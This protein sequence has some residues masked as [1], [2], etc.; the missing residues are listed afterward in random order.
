MRKAAEARPQQPS[1]EV[2][3]AVK[4]HVPVIPIS[5]FVAGYGVNFTSCL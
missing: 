4:L 1:A 5:A 2:K 3:E